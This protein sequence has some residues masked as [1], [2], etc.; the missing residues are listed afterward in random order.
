MK[1]KK[2]TLGSSL[3]FAA[4][5]L[6]LSCNKK[7]NVAPEADKEFDSAREASFAT[8]AVI[9][10]ET[11]VSYAADNQF[12]GY[13][14]TKKPGS[15]GSI[16]HTVDTNSAT[17]KIT[18][19]Y[20]GSV[21]CLDGKRRNGEIIIDY[22]NSNFAIGG[23][24][25]RRPGFKANVNTNNYWVDGYY[26][27][28]AEPFKVNN[29]NAYP[30]N[31]AN[32]NGK[33]E[34]DGY[35]SIREENYLQDSSKNII[36]KGKLKKELLNSNDA[37]IFQT[38]MINPINWVVYSATTG[39]ATNAAKVAY[40][41]NAEGVTKRVVSFKME[42]AD[43]PEKVLYRDFMCAPE[44]VLGVI[45]TP[46]VVTYYSEWHPVIGGVASF[47]T[48]GEG[49]TDPRVIDYGDGTG[50]KPCDN[51]GI[52]TIKGISYPIDFKK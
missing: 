24:F 8:S 34:L 45:T 16:S 52:V 14:F 51:S 27:N 44:Q 21:T 35:F 36:W 2:I 3:I 48:L 11:I 17:K 18:I 41:G 10:I 29:I 15:T 49:T 43:K 42:I 40:S 31:P 26:V 22:S 1:M 28:A 46:S 7:T 30:F 37:A 6:I 23:K 50:S 25:Y 12:N 39:R 38:T 4:S 19:I 20:S 47:T 5:L 13:F 32:A 9:D 33:W